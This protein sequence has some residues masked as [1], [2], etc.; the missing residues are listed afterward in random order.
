MTKKLPDS[1]Q[2]LHLFQQSLKFWKS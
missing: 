1:D 2:P